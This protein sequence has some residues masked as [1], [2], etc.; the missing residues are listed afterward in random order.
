MQK[1][2]RDLIILLSAL[3][4]ALISFILL[5]TTPGASISQ[6]GV[7]IKFSGLLCL[8]GSNGEVIGNNGS[9]TIKIGFSDICG[10]NAIPCATSLISFVLFFPLFF[11]IIFSLINC[12]RQKNAVKNIYL[13]ICSISLI[14]SILIFVTA[15][16]FLSLNQS[17]IGSYDS[18]SL[19]AGYIISGILLITVTLLVAYI[20][21]VKKIKYGNAVNSKINDNNHLNAV[22]EINKVEAIKKYKELYDANAITQEEFEKKKSEL[23]K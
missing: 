22:D 7:F 13:G 5:L 3:I 8:F 9:V 18:H 14:S 23:L 20:T 16:V 4:S 2:K 6:S 17:S 10:Q 21:F 11:G 12:H 1:S 19:G 15:P